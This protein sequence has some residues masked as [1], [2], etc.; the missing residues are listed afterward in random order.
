[1]AQ[2]MSPFR[3]RMHDI[4]FEADTPAGKAFDVILLWAIFISVILVA[5]ETVP[6][7]QT[8]FATLFAISE[9][10]FTILFT[11][12]YFMRI[13]TIKN[14]RKYITSF[15]GIVDLLSILPSYLTLFAIGSHSFMIIR[16]L[17]LLRIFR[18]FKM[19]HYLKQGNIIII[20]LRSSVT[21]IAVFLYFIVLMVCVFGAI[22]YLVEGGREGSGFDSIPRSI[23]WC[24]VTVTTVGFGDITPQTALGQI[25]ASILM[26]VGYAV[27]AVPTGI[28]S[29]DLIQASNRDLANVN[30]QHCTNCGHDDHDDDAHYCKK[31]GHSLDE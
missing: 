7:L 29:S 24:I 2:S 9:W 17:R 30:T 21:K 22:M 20:A 14:P 12:E 4:I 15:Y 3:K 26:I 27:I 1:M 31:C 18:I 8:R 10:V 25:L 5:L 16:A 23:Y 13:Y 11:A 6:S 28:V 19:G